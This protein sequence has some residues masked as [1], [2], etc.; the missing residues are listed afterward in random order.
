MLVF[1]ALSS[2]TQVRVTDLVYF[3]VAVFEAQPL[4]VAVTSIEGVTLI[5]PLQLSVARGG[6]IVIG[7][8]ISQASTTELATVPNFGASLSATVTVKEQASA[9][10]DC[11]EYATVVTPLLKLSPAIV[12]LPVP[13]VAPDKVN[14]KILALQLSKNAG[15]TLSLAFTIVLQL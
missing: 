10:A 13:A 2:A 7:L 9:C 11:S 3:N 8:G 6:V 14:F 4:T 1:P 15:L 5:T 12:P